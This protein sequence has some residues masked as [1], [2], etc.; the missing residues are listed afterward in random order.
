MTS[1]LYNMQFEVLRWVFIGLKK[2]KDTYRH[3][4]AIRDFPFDVC[5]FTI[6]TLFL[7]KLAAVQTNHS[8]QGGEEERATLLNSSI[9][10]FKINF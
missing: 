9:W 8:L 1:F 4:F 2:K 3:E 7:N 10:G 6:P 5:F